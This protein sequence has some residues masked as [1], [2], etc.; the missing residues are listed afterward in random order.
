MGDFTVCSKD[1][2][3]SKGQCHITCLSP[4]TTMAAIYKHHFP[5]STSLSDD[6][7][8]ADVQFHD[9]DSRAFFITPARWSNK[10]SID[11][12]PFKESTHS[13][14][15]GLPPEILIHIL[16]H[17]HSPRDLFNCLRISRTWCECA[18][19]LLW[20]KPAFPKYDT[21]EKMARLLTKPDQS[22][23]YSHF[24]RR[25]NFL[26]LGSQL[27][28]WHCC[29]GIELSPPSSRKIEQFGEPDRF[30]H[31]SSSQML[32]APPRD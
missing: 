5:S 24:I 26:S 12:I 7:D 25:L 2:A 17:L 32:P 31:P 16:K 4:F 8:D 23:N 15:S 1:M 18:V 11:I 21:L 20:H 13:P 3:D 27:R 22:F 6:G 14:M 19:E 30:G 28:R 10:R 9:Q 29:A